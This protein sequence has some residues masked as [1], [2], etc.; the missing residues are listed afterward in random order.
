MIMI[1]V[2]QVHLQSCTSPGHKRVISL[3]CEVQ[4]RISLESQLYPDLEFLGQLH[5]R[6][7]FGEYNIHPELDIV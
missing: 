1:I 2:V 5:V 4:N 6:C 7:E 3:L